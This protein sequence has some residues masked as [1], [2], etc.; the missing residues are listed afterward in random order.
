MSFCRQCHLSQRLQK[1][2][3]LGLQVLDGGGGW[4]VAVADALLCYQ[5]REATGQPL[6][7]GFLI[8]C[9]CNSKALHCKNEEAEAQGQG[10]DGHMANG[11]PVSQ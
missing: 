4:Q 7:R 2:V 9:L 6:N 1:L 8:L 11:W 10:N 3:M 5:V